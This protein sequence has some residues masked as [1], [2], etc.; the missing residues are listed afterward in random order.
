[1]AFQDYS[2][3]QAPMAGGLSTADVVAGASRAGCASSTTPAC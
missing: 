2:L 3:I 1:M